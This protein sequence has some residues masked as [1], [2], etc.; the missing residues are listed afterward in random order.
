[1]SDAIIYVNGKDYVR[2]G[3]LTDNIYIY[4]DGELV[5]IVDGA[6]RH[7][8]SDILLLLDGDKL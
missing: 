5:E 8:L 6:G 3:T 7:V 2:I 1:M 4:E